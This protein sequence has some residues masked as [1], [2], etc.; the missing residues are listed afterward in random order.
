MCDFSGS[1]VD[2]Q[3]LVSV[4]LAPMA[5]RTQSLSPRGGA[6][7]PGARRSS[8]VADRPQSVA[9]GP[10]HLPQVI[11]ALRQEVGRAESAQKELTASREAVALLRREL[12]LRD[13]KVTAVSASLVALKGALEEILGITHGKRVDRRLARAQRIAERGLRKSRV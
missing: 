7:R 1:W 4:T 8:R 3:R 10:A 13:R 9:A 11:R 6:A 2:A 5:K 12:Q